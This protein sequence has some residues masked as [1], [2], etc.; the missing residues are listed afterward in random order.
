MLCE[1]GLSLISCSNPHSLSLSMYRR[2]YRIT[3]FPSCV[4]APTQTYRLLS[5]PSSRAY[6]D[7][8]SL[9]I[10]EHS[11]THSHNSLYCDLLCGL[12]FFL[13]VTVTQ[14]LHLQCGSELPAHSITCLLFCVCLWITWR[15]KLPTGLDT[16]DSSSSLSVS[17][18]VWGKVGERC[19]QGC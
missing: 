5:A 19:Y 17:A 6:R 8:K 11:Y 3:V 10:R 4:R 12:S 1:S 2:H 13:A 7:C 15:I 9:N 18:G 14:W 16:C